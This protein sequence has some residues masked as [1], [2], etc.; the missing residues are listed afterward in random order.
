[1]PDKKKKKTK[2]AVNRHR[3]RTPIFNAFLYFNVDVME[4]PSKFLQIQLWD[5]NPVGTYKLSSIIENILCNQIIY[6]NLKI[7]HSYSQN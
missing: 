2:V 5:L 4:L 6:L 1:M 3:Q 7:R